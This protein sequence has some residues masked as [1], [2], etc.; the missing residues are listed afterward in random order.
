VRYETKAITPQAPERLWA[1]VADVEGWPEFISAYRSVRRLDPGPLTTG[2][3]AHI[4]QFG[5]RPDDWQVSELV[6]GHSFTWRA[7]HPGLVAV[8]WHQVAPGPTGGSELTLG[9]EL[10]GPLAGIA[11]MLLRDKTRRYLDVELT[12]FTT[13]AA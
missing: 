1:R 5:L 13:P 9:L 12:A 6:E 4:V 10:R 3:R 7:R 11:W 8:A 2:S